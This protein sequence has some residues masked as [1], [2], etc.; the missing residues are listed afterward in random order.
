MTC[1]LGWIWVGKRIFFFP[2][3]FF[4]CCCLLPKVNL[5]LLILA[6]SFQAGGQLPETL[7]LRLI[8]LFGA[9]LSGSKV[10]LGSRW[11]GLGIIIQA[12]N[13]NVLFI[14]S[15]INAGIKLL[16]FQKPL[17]VIFKIPALNSVGLP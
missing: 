7:Q 16:N 9:I 11:G 17:K 2:W 15:E 10:A 12:I 14:A 3:F 6:E 4:C 13:P 1:L 8:H 5:S